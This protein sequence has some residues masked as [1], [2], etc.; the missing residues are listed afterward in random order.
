MTVTFGRTTVVEITRATMSFVRARRKSCGLCCTL[1]LCLGTLAAVVV[2]LLYAPRRTYLENCTSIVCMRALSTLESLLDNAVDPCRDFHGHVCHLWDEMHGG[3]VTYI[4]HSLH[5]M[6]HHVGQ[7]L[8][9]VNA[10]SDMSPQTRVVTEF[11][12]LCSR[13]VTAPDRTA[14]LHEIL[15]PLADAYSYLLRL[16]RFS[17]VLVRLVELSL[18]HGVR[19]VF[20]TKFVRRGG[21]AFLAMFPGKTLAQRVLPFPTAS[22]RDY[23][24]TFA[25]EVAKTD[26]SRKFQVDGVL[27][28]NEQLHQLLLPL[29]HDGGPSQ[30]LAVSGL[31]N[32]SGALNATGWLSAL[33]AHLP[34][35]QHLSHESLISVDGYDVLRDV[36][37]LFERQTHDSVMYVYLD[38]L[39]D[40]FRFDYI[41]SLPNKSDT[42][43]GVMCLQASQE[44]IWHTRNVVSNVI[45]GGNDVSKIATTAIFR[46]IHEY[47]LHGGESLL[48]MS[49]A[50]RHQVYDILATIKLRLYDGQ[51]FN[52]SSATISDSSLNATI[53]ASP[54]DFPG[55]YM[56]LKKDQLQA[57]LRNPDAVSD[58]DDRLHFFD[59]GPKHS[60]RENV[61]GV[62]ASV[63]VEPLLYPV[64]VPSAFTAG[65]LGTVMARELHRSSTP[66]LDPWDKKP[67]EAMKKFEECARS[68]VKA[69]LNVS[70][71]EGNTLDESRSLPEY[72]FWTMAA[73]TA[74]GALRES[75]RSLQGAANWDQYWKRA[76][77]TFFRRFCL[78]TCS[79]GSSSAESVEGATAMSRVLCFL[80]LVNMREFADA[81]DCALPVDTESLCVL[82]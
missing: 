68:R 17:D 29:T 18:A 19:T 54:T 67:R 35:T 7:A 55:L 23:L 51:F 81:F 21:T 49:S 43:V 70:L 40:A 71:S 3:R 41:R 80:P 82:R 42:D 60:A 47:A 72:V 22:F 73:R 8:L 24:R 39:V 76:Q 38:V 66:R 15:R 31:E 36:L 77:K 16:N 9:D 69:A 74:Y 25:E 5:H 62:P 58:G 37:Q 1:P 27:T 10:N 63:R 4:E 20:G 2:F 14:P 13:F 53:G 33:N 61:L 46:H 65:T 75:L 48:W 79:A 32:L 57:F 56:R 11:Y 78:L 64:E 52:T 50:M 28:L 45:F 30:L 12:S 6:A 59:N 34:P 26:P 44:S